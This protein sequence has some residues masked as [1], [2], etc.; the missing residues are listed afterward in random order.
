MV[1]HFVLINLT[2]GHIQ[3]FQETSKGSRNTVC[4]SRK[5]RKTGPKQARKGQ[6]KE[7]VRQTTVKDKKRGRNA[8]K[9]K[10]K[11][12]GQVHLSALRKESR[13]FKRT[14]KPHSPRVSWKRVEV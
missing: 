13:G 1:I 10:S 14:C 3:K 12:K 11:D 9:D 5:V 6:G 4:K 7:E 8:C 2:D